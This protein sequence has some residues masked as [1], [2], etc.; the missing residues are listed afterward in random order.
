MA[1]VCPQCAGSYEQ[2]LQCPTCG[3]RLLYDFRGPK[4]RTP[5]PAVRWQQTP[6][7]RIVIGLVLAQGL[8]FGLQNAL[9]GL[10][11]VLNNQGLVKWTWTSVT[12]LVFLQILQVLTLTTGAVF[13]GAGQRR[14]VV[15]GGMVGVWNG[16]LS[17][18]LDPLLHPNFVP[19]LTALTLIGVPLLHVAFGTVGGWVGY[20]IWRPV[21]AE[22]A[23]DPAPRTRKPGVAPLRRPVLAGRI[24]WFRVLLGAVVAAAGY[25]TATAVFAFLIEFSAGRLTSDGWW[26]D[27]VV[28]WEIQALAVFIG[29]AVAGYNTPNGL[30]QGLCVAVPAS[31]F[32][33]VLLTGYTHTPPEVASLTV[34]GC[35]GLCALGGWFSSQLFPPVLSYKFRRMSAAAE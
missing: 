15:L 11:E 2:R 30:K 27:R 14:G 19:E 21:Q 31:V 10:L 6:W 25:M 7:G 13:A 33:A 18:L 9:L 22:A 20:T 5:A 3:V 34:G 8:Y 32:L 28:T 17:V 24:A 4:P 23:P 1:M 12:G 29:G 35:F 26:Q 16:V